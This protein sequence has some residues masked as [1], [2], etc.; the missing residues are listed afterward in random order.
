MRKKKVIAFP[1]TANHW[2]HPGGG[3]AYFELGS[4]FHD[5]VIQDEMSVLIHDIMRCHPSDRRHSR[6]DAW[7]GGIWEVAYWIECPTGVHPN[8]HDLSTTYSQNP[9]DVDILEFCV[10]D[11]HQYTMF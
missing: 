5:W 8:G 3:A 2:H 11:R 10:D 1:C 4:Q 6:Y 7:N 9:R